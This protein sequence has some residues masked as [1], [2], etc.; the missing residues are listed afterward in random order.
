MGGIWLS[1]NQL[2]TWPS[3]IAG[4][5]SGLALTSLR[6]S[7]DVIAEGAAS[8][9]IITTSA[10]SPGTHAVRK[11]RAYPV[12]AA[13]RPTLKKWIQQMRTPRAGVF[14]GE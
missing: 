4:Y 10:L 6:I 14:M 3:E 2:I 9:L 12:Q 1:R 7:T 11:A 5:K 8:G 13:E